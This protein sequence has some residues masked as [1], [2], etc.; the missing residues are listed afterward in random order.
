M[1]GISIMQLDPTNNRFDFDLIEQMVGLGRVMD[2]VI[3][4]VHMNDDGTQVVLL[5]STCDDDSEIMT[6]V[7][8]GMRE[9][10]DDIFKE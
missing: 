7:A 3:F 1:I 8:S 4:T 2:V 6:I 9:D 10:P 5:S